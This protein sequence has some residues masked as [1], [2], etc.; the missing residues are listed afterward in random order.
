VPVRREFNG[1]S[2]VWVVRIRE[3]SASELNG[4]SAMAIHCLDPHSRG[5]L[6][7]NEM[8]LSPE[9]PTVLGENQPKIV[10]ATGDDI[11][12][13]VVVSPGLSEHMRDGPWTAQ[14]LISTP[15]DRGSTQQPP[16]TERS[17]RPPGLRSAGGPH[18]A[19]NR[20]PRDLRW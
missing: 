5:V 20:K 9:K 10:S 3:G 8:P 6:L 14:N 11:L 7:A 17:R 13:G 2:E 15:Y 12:A 1:T 16:P 18:S 4:A 19:T